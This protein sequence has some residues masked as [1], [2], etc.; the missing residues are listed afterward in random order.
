M[1]L[2]K[3]WRKAHGLQGTSF[4]SRGSGLT[5]PIRCLHSPI[6]SELPAP[7][8]VKV[9]TVLIAVLQTTLRLK[10]DRFT[11]RYGLSFEGSV[12]R[13]MITTIACRHLSSRF[14]DCDV[15]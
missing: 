10:F 9:P 13:P 3:A 12:S 15:P 2:F 5:L 6:A 14:G 1:L 7:A 11:L 8:C 4:S